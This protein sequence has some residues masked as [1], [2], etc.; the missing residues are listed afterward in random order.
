M[1]NGLP[2]RP[3]Q[4]PTR[5]RDLKGHRFG[6]LIAMGHLGQVNRKA[7]WRCACDCGSQAEVVGSNLLTGITKSCGCLALETLRTRST[8][9]GDSPRGRVTAEYRCHNKMKERCLNPRDKSFSRYGGRGIT[10][11]NRWLKG[12]GAQSG[13]EAFLA[14]MG[15]KPTAGHSIDRIDVN[16]NYEPSNCRWATAKQQNNNRRDN[17]ARRRHQEASL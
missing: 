1:S 8:T 4:K 9:H 6:R 13:F 14:D 5:V 3:S 2:I 11:C 17:V 16:G 10:I 7:L 15:R 12:E